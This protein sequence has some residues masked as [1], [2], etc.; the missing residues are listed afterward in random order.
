MNTKKYFN[1]IN[2]YKYI[3]FNIFDTLITRNLNKPTE[4]FDL[5]Q[6]EINRENID[7]N[8]FKNKRIEAEKMVSENINEREYTINDIYDEF[9]KIVNVESNVK[10]ETIAKIKEIEIKIEISMCEVN[11][12]FYNVYDCCKKNNK[13]IIITSDMYLT[14]D[15]IEK[16]LEKNNLEYYKLYLS[17]DIGKRKSTGELYKYILNDLKIEPNEMIH[18]GDNYKSDYLRPKMLGISSKLVKYNDNKI[19]KNKE[20]NT[21]KYSILV[22]YINNNITKIKDSYFYKLGFQVFGPL[23]YGY[24]KWLGNKLEENNYDKIF[25]LSRDG[26]IMQKA[27]N[28]LFKKDNTYMYAS[29]RALIVPTLYFNSKLEEI[30]NIM[31]LPRVMK[32]KNFITKMGLDAKKYENFVKENGY[33]LEQVVTIKDEINK[34]NFINLY[35]EL[36]PYI[37]ENAEIEYKNLLKYLKN[38][39]FTGNIAIIDIGWF[40]NMQNALQNI[41]NYSKI[42]ANI[43]GYYVG[44]IPD[45]NNQKKLKMHGYL[46][47]KNKN[48]DLFLQK[49]FFNSIFEIFFTADHG[50]LLNYIDGINLDKFEYENT[51]TYDNVKEI[52]NGALKF[53]ELFGE[54]NKY[55]YITYSEVDA[56]QNFLEFGNNPSLNDIKMFENF[57]FMDDELINV[58]P[59][60]GFC[61]YSFHPRMF[62]NNLRDSAWKTAFLKKIFKL[63]INYYVIVKRMREKKVLKNRRG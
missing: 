24:S 30:P 50:T 4:L 11:Y 12:S 32:I 21:F 8:D 16:I 52:Q 3:S 44:I 49:K 7:I 2:K 53:I 17:S 59:K 1:L 40:G 43:D 63:N 6:E 33:D 23:L 36:L 48:E 31:F 37:K 62:K 10:K 54:Y 29:R 14:K 47:E 55:N 61:Y 9:Y 18:F 56:V 51:E 5:V 38:I 26:Q 57:V 13:K 28:L 35:S 60:H 58:I 34:N 15:I 45:S 27:Y 42:Y 20:Y 46:F 25:F 41:I 39:N 22:N 19:K